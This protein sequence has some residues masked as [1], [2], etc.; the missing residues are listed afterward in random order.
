MR[1]GK[2]VEWA[3]VKREPC[4]GVEWTDLLTGE[5]VDEQGIPLAGQPKSTVYDAYLIPTREREMNE[6]ALTD[7]QQEQVAEYEGRGAEVLAHAKEYAVSTAEGYAALGAMVADYRRYVKAVKDFFE[8]MR[9]DADQTKKRILERRQ[10]LTDP[11]ESAIG[12]LTEKGN[13]YRREQARLAAEA[14]RT[15]REAALAEQRTRALKEALKAAEANNEP[16]FERAAAL[17]EEQVAPT[18]VSAETILAETAPKLKGQRIRTTWTAKLRAPNE[19]ALRALCK[20]V[21]DGGPIT[22]VEPNL[23][24]LAG[25][26]EHTGG[27]AQ[28]PGVEF[29]KV[30][31]VDFT[32]GR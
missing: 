28:V 6:I 23:K 19:A 24:A 13:A 12:V 10:F 5:P 2:E 18:E 26:A 15:A 32:S 16:R 7:E 8:P 25:L 4:I 31:E 9:R 27:T 1:G 11:F 22:L 29:K 21:A 14:A 17:V 20:Y 30:E 3:F